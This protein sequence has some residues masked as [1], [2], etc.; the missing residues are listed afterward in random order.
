MKV[1]KTSVKDFDVSK[2]SYEELFEELADDL[3]V[4]LERIRSSKYWPHVMELKKD[5]CVVKNLKLK[6]EEVYPCVKLC[7]NWAELSGNH[8]NIVEVIIS[9]FG[10]KY[11][12][13]IQVFECESEYLNNAIKKLMVKKFPN[14][15]YLEEYNKYY[16]GQNLTK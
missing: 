12:D 16:S 11:Y 2:I 3:K 15:S 5:L 4:A 9:P 1:E 10:A 8:G 6:N 7:I 13:I 14:S